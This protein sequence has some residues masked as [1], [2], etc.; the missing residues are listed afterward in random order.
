RFDSP[1]V[2]AKVSALSCWTAGNSTT[3]GEIR[4][5]HLLRSDLS[6][7]SATICRKWGGIP[8]DCDERCLVWY[9]GGSL[10]TF[11]NGSVSFRRK[12]LVLRSFRQYR[13]FRIYR[14]VRTDR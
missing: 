12:S 14:S 9:N 5:S 10:A 7:P 11:F 8:G 4:S 3:R 6:K 13:Y 2:A 1:D